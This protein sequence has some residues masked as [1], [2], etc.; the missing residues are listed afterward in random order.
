MPF[1]SALMLSETHAACAMADVLVPVFAVLAGLG[2][3]WLRAAHPPA[4]G[5]DPVLAALPVV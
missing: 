4:H 1:A 5:H 2:G 3:A